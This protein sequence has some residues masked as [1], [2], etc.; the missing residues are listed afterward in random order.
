MDVNVKKDHKIMLLVSWNDVSQSVTIT[1][2][3]ITRLSIQS[4]L[5]PQRMTEI[6]VV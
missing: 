2:H 4:Q 3:L 5:F 6:D 1:D